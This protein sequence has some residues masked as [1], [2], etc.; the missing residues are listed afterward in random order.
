MSSKEGRSKISAVLV[1]VL[2]FSLFMPVMAFGATTVH[3]NDITNSYAQ[4]EIQALVDGG[5]ISGYEDGSFQP[6]KAMSRAELAKIIV[7]SQGLKENEEKASVFTDVDKNSWYRGFVGALV[8][9]GI[10]Q[11]KSATT[12]SPDAK[13]T[14]EELVVFFVR[15]L[16]LEEIAGKLAADVKLSDLRE[17][18]NWAQVDVW[19]AFKIGFVNGIEK[20]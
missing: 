15:A 16:G 20:Q 19:L 2:L 7:L 11:G 12:F 14:R 4:K 8:E 10:T 5:I 13:V 1:L 17:V 18:S 6:R 9:S 3:L